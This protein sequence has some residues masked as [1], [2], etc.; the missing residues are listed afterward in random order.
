MSSGRR[1]VLTGIGLVTPLGVGTKETWAA[2]LAG[3]SGIGPITHF[4]AKDLPTRFAG[5]VKGFEAERF[6]DKKEV[7]RNDL[8]IQYAMA[9]AQLALED[10]GLPTDQPLG[11]D[12]GCVVGSGM[13]G[14]GTLEETRLTL[15]ERG[16]R[17]VGPF[18]IPSIIINLAAGQISIRH[19]MTGPNWAPVSACATGNHAIGESMR[20]IEHGD[21][22]AILCGGTEATITP[23][24]IVGFV[25]ARALSERN[26]APEKASRPFDKDRDGFVAGEGAGLLMIEELE[27]AKKR[28]ARIYCE[29]VGYSANADAYHITAPSGE[30][31]IRAMRRC[32]KDA[33]L[34]PEDVGYVNAHGTST[35]VGDIAE[36]KAI[37]EVFGAHATSRKLAVS[38]TK[39]MTGH[40]LGAAGGVEAALTALALHH[41]VLPPT[42]NLEN[43]DPECDLDYV[44]NV[45]RE[46]RVDA[47]LSNSFGFGGTNAVVALKRFQG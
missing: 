3:K 10:A 15:H 38:S 19:G 2:A 34:N 45:A 43:P 36:T 33:K 8:F 31:A 35:P 37:K 30:G 16:Y 20:L 18:F 1:V 22:E 26:D 40:L 5:E 12:Y 7:R 44:P 41:G 42:I 32:L 6:L 29:L 46:V 4:D 24:G 17:K 27:H 9:A 11:E 13:G 39:S 23:L 21:A 47:A 14:L 25:A 28:G